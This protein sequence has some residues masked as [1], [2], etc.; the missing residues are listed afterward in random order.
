[1]KLV[2]QYA[3][4]D[5]GEQLAKA[6]YE[7][8]DQCT[9]RLC[10]PKLSPIKKDKPKQTTPEKDNATHIKK[11][12]STESAFI[13]NELDRYRCYP[14][15][16]CSVDDR[17]AEVTLEEPLQSKLSKKSA[18]LSDVI[19]LDSSDEELLE[20]SKHK[21]QE[22]TVSTK[23]RNRGNLIVSML[24]F[25]ESMESISAHSVKDYPYEIVL[26]VDNREIKDKVHK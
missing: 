1:M 12:S 14:C 8:R 5:A 21:Q 7:N 20:P 19:C 18:R 15:S 4:T 3:L 25:A 16:Y 2:A 6:L 10:L 23:K 22:N 11:D 9:Q 13:S 17:K 26:L 24:N